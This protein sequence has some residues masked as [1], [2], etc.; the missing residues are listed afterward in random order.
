[1][2]ESAGA[3]FK[4]T[5][6]IPNNTPDEVS[7]GSSRSYTMPSVIKRPPVRPGAGE[8]NS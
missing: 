3:S 4:I 8:I 7:E 5:Q 6:T 2:A 1:M